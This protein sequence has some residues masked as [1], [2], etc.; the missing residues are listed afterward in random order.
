MDDQFYFS[1]TVERA[2][3]K[4]TALIIVGVGYPQDDTP[5]FVLGLSVNG[6]QYNSKS[7]LLL[8]NLEHEINVSLI[9]RI[10]VTSSDSLLSTQMAFLVSRCDVIL[11]V[12]SALTESTG[13]PREHL[14]TRLARGHDLQ[15]PLNFDDV[16]NTFTFSSS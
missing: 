16:S 14:F 9:E 3:A 2:T 13:F 10:D 4:L 5:F 11:E 15:P 6:K 7:S 8:Q 12:N 1:A